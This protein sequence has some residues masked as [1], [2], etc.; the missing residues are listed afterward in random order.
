MEGE[1][2]ILHTEPLHE[3]VRDA[4]NIEKDVCMR[5]DTVFESLYVHFEN[6]GR[7]VV[8]ALSACVTARKNHNSVKVVSQDVA[9]E[10]VD[11]D[12]MGWMGLDVGGKVGKEEGELV[13]ED[14]VDCRRA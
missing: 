8:V 7:E 14:C 2:N 12:G 13:E 1:V 5:E 4:I 6:G 3:D 11:V 10:V 9:E